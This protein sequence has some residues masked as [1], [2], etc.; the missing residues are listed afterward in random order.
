MKIGIIRE[1]KVPPDNRVVLTPRQCAFLMRN[2]AV[3]IV[4][5]P[6]SIRCYPDA[7][8]VNEGVAVTNNLSDCDMLL[9]IKEVPITQ[10]MPDKTYF[11]F[12]HTVK[13]QV[14]NRTLLQ[15]VLQKNIK[16]VDYELLTDD[17]GLRL[18]AF[19]R[20]AGMVGAH[21][22]MLAYGIRTGAYRMV[23]MKD[24]HDYAQARKMYPT[25]QLPP[26]RVV[27]TGTGRVA[28]GAVE[29]LR[30]LGLKQ[31]T[32][33]NFLNKN[34]NTA[35]FTQ[36]SA[37]EYVERKDGLSFKKIDFYTHPN[38]YKSSFAPFYQKTDVFING[39]FYDKKAPMFFT[40]EEMKQNDFKIRTIADISCDLMPHSSVPS[41]IRATTI[42]EP[43]YGFDPMLNQE[44]APFQEKSIDMMTIDNLPNELPRD[45]SEFFGTQFMDNILPEIL[46]AKDS[47]VLHRATIAEKGKLTE[48]YHYLQDYVDYEA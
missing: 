28:S 7:E 3:Q 16:L 46:K 27:V 4:V 36:L 34:F 20:Y 37:R 43:F 23:R 29:V 39:I 30:D 9:G 22:G 18:L 17:H 41:T 5:E 45:A 40:V 21:N 25:I 6:S 19:G 8:Y 44:T 13:K 33:S 2:Y 32:P 35:I 11:F 24:L 47:I 10:L 42:A 26:V 14:Y 12:S 38:R 15:T 31:V 1:G 48:K